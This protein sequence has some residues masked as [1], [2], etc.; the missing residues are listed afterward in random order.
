M[1]DGSVEEA[2]GQPEALSNLG[3]SD[4]WRAPH[5]ASLAVAGVLALVAAAATGMGT[6]FAMPPVAAVLLAGA[7]TLLAGLGTSA[8]LVELPARQIAARLSAAVR[9]QPADGPSEIGVALSPLGGLWDAARDVQETVSGLQSDVEQQ[10]RQAFTENRQALKA[11]RDA[12]K[13][14]REV[15][16]ARSAA[17]IE[18]VGEV[19]GHVEAA[20]G[21][22]EAMLADSAS[23]IDLVAAQSR[24]LG[25]TFT[26][27]DSALAAV[28]EASESA[29]QAAAKAQ[30]AAGIAENGRRLENDLRDVC[31]SLATTMDGLAASFAVLLDGLR[32]AANTGETIADIADQTNMLAL[33]AAIEA[34]RAGEHGRGFAVVADEVRRLAES[35]KQAAVQTST[36]LDTVMVQAE[37]NAGL[38]H[39]AHEA[40][41]ELLDLS[42]RVGQALEAIASNAAGARAMGSAG[43]KP[44]GVPC[45][46]WPRSETPST[47]PSARPR[48]SRK[49]LLPARTTPGDCVKPSRAS[50]NS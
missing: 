43:L 40:T 26:L 38:L 1:K 41:G 21:R 37:G 35:S 4:C 32:F 6:A 14:R 25:T 17:V 9:G 48:P 30:E 8:A 33:N 16:A 23:T 24:N 29:L 13:A 34:A 18:V 39:I 5:P 19:R 28:R 47:K 22:A 12:A 11:L 31:G 42:S 49:P 7:A 45:P 46:P 2:A 20:A 44:W 10:R 27:L 50:T 15:D 36:R 3:I